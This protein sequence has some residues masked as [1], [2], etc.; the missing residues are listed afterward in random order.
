[1]RAF[2]AFWVAIGLWVASTATHDRAYPDAARIVAASDGAAPLLAKIP[3]RIGAQLRLPHPTSARGGTPATLGLAQRDALTWLPTVGDASGE[4]L[5]GTVARSL[6]PRR[7]SFPYEA[8]APPV[9]L[10]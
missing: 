9:S 4:S 2:L 1:L 6:R 10:S 8:T 3:E 5:L 7:V